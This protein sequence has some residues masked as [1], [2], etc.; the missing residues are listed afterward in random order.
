ME[1]QTLQKYFPLIAFVTGSVLLGGLINEFP[2]QEGG[3]AAGI[4]FEC[5]PPSLPSVDADEPR[6]L[7]M[8]SSQVGINISHVSSAP[9]GL[10]PKPVVAF[11]ALLL[12]LLPILAPTVVVG[13]QGGPKILSHFEQG[14]TWKLLVCH[15][16]GQSG[17]F[18]SS[19][20]AR[21]LIVKPNSQFFS[22]CQL[23][24]EECKRIKNEDSA[25]KRQLLAVSAAGIHNGSGKSD[26]EATENVLCK[27]STVSLSEL[28]KN[29]HSFPDVASA[30]VGAAIC[31]FFL[32]MSAR[33]QNKRQLLAVGEDDNQAEL[34]TLNKNDDD[35]RSSSSPCRG[36]EV[37]EPKT[38]EKMQQMTL[39]LTLAK[40]YLK[41]LYVTFSVGALGLLLVDRYALSK[42][43]PLEMAFSV[44]LGMF[45]QLTIYYFMVGAGD[46][47]PSVLI[48]AAASSGIRGQRQ[49]AHSS[50]IISPRLRW[51][52]N[53]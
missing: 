47:W 29:L 35:A 24:S 1:I 28:Q 33:R 32:S 18:S 3:V 39:S 48:A 34:E 7:P 41:F 38:E 14:D 12:P 23:D 40:P 25:T 11:I 20:L 36:A 43:S 46:K 37:R 19:E 42:Y 51:H 50:P 22:D 5:P 26:T 10:L 45:F 31:S 16:V 30:L 6:V 4:D 53:V 49:P 52:S 13:H 17:S 15:I 9:G 2:L 27:N 44:L 8:L 21:F